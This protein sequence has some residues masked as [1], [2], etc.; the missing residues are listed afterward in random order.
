[1]TGFN[2]DTHN[3]ASWI[4]DQVTWV[5]PGNER[6]FWKLSDPTKP[7]ITYANAIDF[8]VHTVFHER[9]HRANF[10]NWWTNITSKAQWL[11]KLNAKDGTGDWD[12][13]E[14]MDVFLKQWRRGD[15]IPDNLERDAG[16]N[17]GA[18]GTTKRYLKSWRVSSGRSA[19]AWGYNDEVN[20]DDCEDY[21]LWHQD[22]PTPDEYGERDWAN[23]GS[24]YG[25]K[26]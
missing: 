12:G 2:D 8:F 23:P 21:T 15:H 18:D 3:W 5:R 6:T 1:V 24:Q 4:G 22:W 16:E 17:Q 19:D 13:P 26:H 7:R 25:V 14:V 10:A 9:Q 20:Y 11:V